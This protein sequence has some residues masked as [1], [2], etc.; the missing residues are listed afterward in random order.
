ML[1]FSLVHAWHP[2]AIALLGLSALAYALLV[3]FTL[4]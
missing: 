2:L 3:P 1:F 4:W